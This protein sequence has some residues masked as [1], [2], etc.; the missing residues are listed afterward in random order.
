MN[1]WQARSRIDDYLADEL[2]REDRALLERHLAG[3]PTCP[4]LYA[5]IVGVTE[6]LGSAAR[7][8]LGGAAEIA[9]RAGP[10][11]PGDRRP[12]SAR[13][14]CAAARLWSRRPRATTT[15][16][17]VGA[18]HETGAQCATRTS[19]HGDAGSSSTRATRCCPPRASRRSSRDAVPTDVQLTVTASPTKG[20][21]ETLATT[22]RL[23]RSGVRRRTTPRGPDGQRPHRA[24]GDRGPAAGTGGHQRVRAREVTPSPGPAIPTRWR[25]WRTWP[26]WGG[27][28]GH[29]GHRGLPRVAPHDPRRRDHPVDVGQAH[30]TPPTWSAT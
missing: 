24:G 27:R 15:L 6:A 14:R 9:G 11:P 19:G 13:L 22:E 23:P 4:A 7:P 1:C 16:T 30:A 2:A 3:C 17:A 18:Y 29:V 5:S 28:F 21:G 8:G 12:R 25:C 20:L 10:R 26:R